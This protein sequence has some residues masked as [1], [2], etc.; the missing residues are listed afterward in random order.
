[1]AKYTKTI[2]VKNAANITTDVQP[3]QW[4]K[5]GGK[6]HRLVSSTNCGVVTVGRTNGK[7]N[8]ATFRLARGKP[9]VKVLGIAR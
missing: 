1:M 6:T 2:A 4:L 9:K 3:G 7:V 8:L 5:V